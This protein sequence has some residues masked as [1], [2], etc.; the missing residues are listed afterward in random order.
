MI[1]LPRKKIVVPRRRQRGNLVIFQ[2]E[3][4][5]PFFNDVTQLMSGGE[6]PN[7]ATSISSTVGPTLNRQQASGG[8]AEVSNEQTLFG[9]NS[10]KVFDDTGLVNAEF[11]TPGYFAGGHFDGDFTIEWH[12]YIPGPQAWSFRD[13][14]QMWDFP[15]REWRIQMTCNDNNFRYA[16]QISQFGSDSLLGAQQLWTIG[17]HPTGGLQNQWHYCAVQREGND[18]YFHADGFE[19]GVGENSSAPIFDGSSGPTLFRVG[20]PNENMYVTNIRITNGVARYGSGD[21]S[22]PTE[23]YPTF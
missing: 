2:A 17:N 1:W 14:L 6:A 11:V 10:L 20:P 9:S 18:F 5:D 4:Q 3:G 19:V 22:P 12:I 7:G 8:I 13:I 21:Y 16:L 15:D 23:A